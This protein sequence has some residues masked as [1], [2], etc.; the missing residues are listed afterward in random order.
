MPTFVQFARTSL[1]LARDTGMSREGIYKAFSDGGNPSFATVAKIA[2]A[3]GLRIAF[4]P[5]RPADD[6]VAGAAV[7][8]PPIGGPHILA[9]FSLSTF[10]AR[11]HLRPMA[12]P[13]SPRWSRQ[14]F[15]ISD[16]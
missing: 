5:A 4:E 7:R 16:G 2:Q 3:L 6:E 13:S 1:K 12:S 8:S 15:R 9:R 14:S 10:R 11:I